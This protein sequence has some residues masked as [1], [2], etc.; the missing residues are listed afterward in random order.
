MGLTRRG[1][2]SVEIFS[3]KICGPTPRFRA[4]G[5]TTPTGRRM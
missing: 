1:A 2:G 3:K 4:E 5:W